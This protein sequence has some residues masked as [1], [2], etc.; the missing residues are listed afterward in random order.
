MLLFTLFPV[1]FNVDVMQY[2]VLFSLLLFGI[3]RCNSY[4]HLE[5][6]T[7]ECGRRICVFFFYVCVSS[8]I[9]KHACENCKISLTK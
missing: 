2:I 6:A 9:V 8:Y 7:Q 1:D 3:I 5:D 4:A